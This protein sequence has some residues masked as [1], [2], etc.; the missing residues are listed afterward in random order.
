MFLL[1]KDI[2]LCLMD[3][4]TGKVIYAKQSKVIVYY[5]KMNDE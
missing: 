5:E 4:V 1:A 3:R 2:R